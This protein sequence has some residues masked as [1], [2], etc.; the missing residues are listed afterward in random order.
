MK[1][2]LLLLIILTAGCVNQGVGPREEAQDLF[3]GE[4]DA[5]V[6]SLDIETFNGFIEVHFWD[7][8]TMQIKVEKWVRGSSAQE[9]LH[10]MEVQ[11][12][13]NKG[14]ISVKVP[15]MTNAGADISV[16]IPQM[17]IDTVALTTSNH[18]IELEEITANTVSLNTSN[19]PV[20]AY[21]TAD[22]I[23]VT[24]SNGSVH[25]VFDGKTVTIKTSNAGIDIEIGSSGDYNITTSN[26]GID[27]AANDDFGFD[28][29]TSNGNITVKDGEIVYA[30]T[31]K[32]HKKGFTAQDAPVFVTASTSNG[33]ITVVMK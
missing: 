21:V 17:P 4:L 26:A 13:S 20:T 15:S 29:N 31:D 18:H 23:T 12:T 16:F 33:S 28:L 11:Y 1:K 14:K 24:T 25:G 2:I 27:I 22:T 30:L 10:N 8:K 7:K 5:D 3:E 9:K 32:T 6:I 19:G